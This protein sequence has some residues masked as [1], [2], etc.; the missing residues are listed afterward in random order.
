MRVQ[1]KETDMQEIDIDVLLATAKAHSDECEACQSSITGR[2]EMDEC[3][4]RAIVGVLV[5]V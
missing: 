3:G 5:S 2:D 1:V 4:T